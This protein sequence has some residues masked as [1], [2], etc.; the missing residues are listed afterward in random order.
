MSLSELFTEE[1]QQE[2]MQK[3]MSFFENSGERIFALLEP[4][5]IDDSYCL[6]IESADIPLLCYR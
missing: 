1:E 2:A 5:E 4:V 3:V 6:V